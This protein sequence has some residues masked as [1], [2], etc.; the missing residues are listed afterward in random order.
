MAT[1]S[2]I[3]AW[4][5]AGTEEPGGQHT[6]THTHTQHSQ[7]LTLVPLSAPFLGH[8]SSLK[9]SLLFLKATGCVCVCVCGGQGGW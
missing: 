8:D 4:R 5:I 6:H 2:G 9:I 3:L 1:H 7:N